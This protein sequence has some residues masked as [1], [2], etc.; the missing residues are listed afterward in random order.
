MNFYDCF[1][2]GPQHKVRRIS[3]GSPMR[4]RAYGSLGGLCAC[5]HTS[6]CDCLNLL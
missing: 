4:L 5:A 1:V 6:A 3:V 2:R